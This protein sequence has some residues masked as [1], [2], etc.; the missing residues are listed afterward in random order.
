MMLMIWMRSGRETT[1]KPSNLNLRSTEY[2]VVGTKYG[3]EIHDAPNDM[4]HMLVAS[5]ITWY[6][7]LP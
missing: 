1:A 7:A 3:P 4:E 2:Y 6:G 5:R